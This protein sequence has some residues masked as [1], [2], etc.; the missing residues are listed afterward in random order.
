MKPFFSYK[1]GNSS[2]HFGKKSAI[3][4]DKNLI[5]HFNQ[6]IG[7]IGFFEALRDQNEAVSK[8]FKYAEEYLIKSKIEVIWAP[9]NGDANDTF[10]LLSDAYDKDPF[11]RMPYNPPYYHDYLK[12]NSL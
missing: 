8:L 11:F 3:F 5:A 4:L 7:L 9:F 10:G 12:E 6:K 1:S 2:C